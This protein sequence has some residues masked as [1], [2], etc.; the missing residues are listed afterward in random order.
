MVPNVDD[1][2]VGTTAVTSSPSRE[3]RE[4]D[5]SAW[6]ASAGAAVGMVAEVA[7][8]IRA[9][10]TSVSPLTAASAQSSPA[11][12]SISDIGVP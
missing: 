9:I 7:A 12:G 10:S 3:D 5:P 8:S 11:G 6:K 2:D 1:D 4:G